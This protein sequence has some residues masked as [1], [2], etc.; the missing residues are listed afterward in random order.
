M[1]AW[2]KSTSKQCSTCP[3]CRRDLYTPACSLSQRDFLHM[4]SITHHLQRRDV[5]Y[6]QTL[7][8]GPPSGGNDFVIRAMGC[9]CRIMVTVAS[10]WE[11]PDL[12]LILDSVGMH[13]PRLQILQ[14]Q[15]DQLLA[16]NAQNQSATVE[17]RLTRRAITYGYS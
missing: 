15:Q 6:V 5:Q 12:Y 7:T 14:D 2:F 1:L 8:P 10:S 9:D 17:L 3:M 16:S 11:L 4:T 13:S